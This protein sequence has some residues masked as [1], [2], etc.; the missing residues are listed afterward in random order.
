LNGKL[1]EFL[2][3]CYE[4]AKI[5]KWKWPTAEINYE[6]LVAEINFILIKIYKKLN[7]AIMKRIIVSLTALIIGMS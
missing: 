6:W 3:T 5:A 2:C 1:S 7:Q 4:L